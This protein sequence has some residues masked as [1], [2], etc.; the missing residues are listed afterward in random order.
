M[1]QHDES[2]FLFRF[3]VA[4]LM[5]ATFMVIVSDDPLW[6]SLRLRRLS[7]E[8]TVRQVRS[9]VD[10]LFLQ[11]KTACHLV[12]KFPTF[13]NQYRRLPTVA[14]DHGLVVPLPAVTTDSRHPPFRAA[15]NHGLVAP[16]AAACDILRA[17]LSRT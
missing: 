5:Q 16:R 17:G 2:A 11:M 12:G 13:F 8:P 14:L 1:D 7:Y 6:V 9:E 15:T 3:E 4:Q 10:C